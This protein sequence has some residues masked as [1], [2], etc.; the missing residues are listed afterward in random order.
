MSTLS[1]SPQ[2]QV[3]LSNIWDY[4]ALS[5][6]SVEVADDFIDVLRTR[7]RELARAPHVGRLRPELKPGLRTLPFRLYLIVYCEREDMVEI[8][9]VLHGM[10]DTHRA[11]AE[12]P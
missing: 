5:S 4:V 7:C 12:P 3:D 10:R 2:A 1:F 9:R 8:V 6:G 11:I